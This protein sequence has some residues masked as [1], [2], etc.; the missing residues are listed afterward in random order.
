[1]HKIGEPKPDK[2]KKDKPQKDKAK[3]NRKRQIPLAILGVFLGA[4]AFANLFQTA[5]A[6]SLGAIVGGVGAYRYG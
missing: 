3:V 5:W 2:P 4:F 6:V 1:M